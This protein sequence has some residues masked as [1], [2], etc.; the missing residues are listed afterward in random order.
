MRAVGDT[1][2]SER[3]NNH[4]KE[5]KGLL[6]LTSCP[7]A[8]HPDEKFTAPGSQVR[9]A[10]FRT[11]F[12]SCILQFGAVFFSFCFLTDFFSNGAMLSVARRM[13]DYFKWVSYPLEERSHPLLVHRRAILGDTIILFD[14]SHPPTLEARNGNRNGGWEIRYDYHPVLI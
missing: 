5:H 3:Y 12:L 1:S 10:V 8:N 7:C 2:R 6:K 9:S 13:R 11:K 4:F 14:L